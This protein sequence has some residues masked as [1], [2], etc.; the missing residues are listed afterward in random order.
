MRRLLNVGLLVGLILSSGACLIV[1]SDYWRRQPVPAESFTRTFD[2]QPG[3]DV[4]L[5]NLDGDIEIQG[6]DSDEAEVFVEK[7][8][9]APPNWEFGIFRKGSVLADVRIE[10]VEGGLRVQTLPA[11]GG[12]TGGVNY[13]LRLPHHV[14]LRRVSGRSGQIVVSGVYGQASVEL[15]EGDVVVE[16]A[17]GSLSLF[18]ERGSADVELLDVREQDS[19]RITANNGDVT[20]RLEPNV[21]ARIDVSASQ[22][23]ESEF[24]TEPVSQAGRVRLQLG[25]GGAEMSV[26]SFN[27]RVRIVR[28]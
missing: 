2:L 6:W 24:E 27:G 11:S 5:E 17:S 12:A 9:G 4:F 26:A 23:V 10:T 19:V 1:V 7:M 28:Q 22:P 13:I 25:E 20:L 3:S 8:F 16:N 14:N 18:I 15:I 21:N